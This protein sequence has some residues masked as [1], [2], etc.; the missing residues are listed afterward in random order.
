MSDVTNLNIEQQSS[1]RVKEFK[2]LALVEKDEYETLPN[3]RFENLN[4]VV[5]T[6]WK[7]SILEALKKPSKVGLIEINGSSVHNFVGCTLPVLLISI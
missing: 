5:P 1:Y 7:S 3:G 2:N 4:N 6:G